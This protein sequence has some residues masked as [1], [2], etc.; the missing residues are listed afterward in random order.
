MHPGPRPS[1]GFQ[2]MGALEYLCCMLSLALCS[3]LTVYNVKFRRTF[4]SKKTKK[5]CEMR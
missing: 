1:I 5:T 3:K 2:E 4:T